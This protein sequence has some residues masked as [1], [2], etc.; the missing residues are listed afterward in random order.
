MLTFANCSISNSV[1]IES[2]LIKAN[3]PLPLVHLIMAVDNITFSSGPYQSPRPDCLLLLVQLVLTAHKGNGG[4]GG[5][6][7][8]RLRD[9]VG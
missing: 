5:E 4:V 1:V 3:P 6:V 7:G 2:E 8:I 9:V